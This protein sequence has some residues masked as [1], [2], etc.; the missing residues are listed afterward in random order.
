MAFAD[1][2]PPPPTSGPTGFWR[3]PVLWSVA[4]L[5]V[6]AVLAGVFAGVEKVASAVER[7]RAYQARIAPFYDPPPDFA[8]KPVGTVLRREPMSVP[9]PGA[10]SFRVLYRSEDSTG[11]ATVSS[12]MVFVPTG[13]APAGGWPV[14]AWAHGTVGMGDT[15]A[16]S[17]SLTPEASFT[18]APQAIRAGY[19]ITA[20][21]YAGLGTPGTEHYLVGGDEARDVVNSVRAARTVGG[22]ANPH[23]VVYGHSQGG[24]AALWTG[25][26]ARTYAP[27]LD[28]TA[29]AAAAP[30][31]ELAPLLRLQRSTAVAWIIGPEVAAAWPL[32]YPDLDVDAVLTSEGKRFGPGIARRCIATTGAI[33][34][35]ALQEIGGRYFARDPGTRPDWQR[36]LAD[37]TPPP[38]PADLPVLIG[39]GLADTVV[40]P[41]TTALLQQRWCAAGSRLTV[42]WI[43]TLQHIPAG[44]AVGPLAVTD[45]EQRR[46]GIPAGTTCG[47]TLPVAPAKG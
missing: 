33:E 40:L 9:I 7:N 28:L 46:A 37:Q 13:P 15:C 47:T 36:A 14:L 5:V 29:V 10:R 11:R 39:Q 2:P 12:G 24:H 41:P 17:R 44:N 19:V 38:L 43:G 42:D 4:A 34:G 6:I 32:V 21:D 18:W 3:H 25:T 26:V 22:T 30:A 35:L 23:W 45:F 27:E 31:A 20:T 8:A 16:P 1:L